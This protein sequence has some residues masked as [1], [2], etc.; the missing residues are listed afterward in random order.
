MNPNDPDIQI[1]NDNNDKQKTRLG[2]SKLVWGVIGII[3][4]LAFV[5][6]LLP[7]LS[8][9][10]THSATAQA[11]EPA[12]SAPEDETDKKPDAPSE[13]EKSSTNENDTYCASV[14]SS[15]DKT[16]RLYCDSLLPEAR[17]VD[18]RL[19]KLEK[20]GGS[21][22]VPAWLI[23]ALIALAASQVLTWTMLAKKRD[24]TA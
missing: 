24:K 6:F 20:G 5:F 23:V 15:Q 16:D 4:A 13:E 8:S 3:A 12:K 14:A 21:S 19:D 18:E 17:K 10:S 22:N 7:H 11:T 1:V 2:W 9:D